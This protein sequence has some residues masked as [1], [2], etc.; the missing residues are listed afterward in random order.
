MLYFDDKLLVIVKSLE[1]SIFIQEVTKQINSI[2]D[3]YIVGCMKLIFVMT[4][5]VQK[6]PKFMCHDFS[7]FCISPQTVLVTYRNS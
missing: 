6:Y 7:S 3:T 1:I 5:S 4:I 2:H